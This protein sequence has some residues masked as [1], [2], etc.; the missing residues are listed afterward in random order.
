MITA[1]YFRQQAGTLLRLAHECRR[2]DTADRLR[3]MAAH[4]ETKAR[5]MA[6]HLETKAHE[7]ETGEADESRCSPQNRRAQ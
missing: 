5:L 1:S 3:L 2:P 7:L 4:L 6:A